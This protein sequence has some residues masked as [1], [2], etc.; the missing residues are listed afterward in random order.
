MKS[1]YAQT[2]DESVLDPRVIR[3][4]RLLLDAFKELLQ[5]RSAIRDVS[6]Q[7]IS[8][9]AGVNRVTFYAHFTDKYELLDFWKRELFR[10]EL[11][12]RQFSTDNPSLEQLID[13]VLEFM[14]NY[15]RN[16]RT[17]INR[18]FEPLFEAAIQNEIQ[19][20]LLSMTDINEDEAIFLSW[21]IFG[22]SNEWSSKHNPDK[23][24]KIASRLVKM[25][26]AVTLS[27]KI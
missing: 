9:R 14:V 10:K 21:A 8:E 4:R 17:R 23:K 6:I 15:R 5:E 27:D 18:Q 7:A 1:T 2:T 25:V 12:K 26:N 13:A 22:S 19:K 16:L 11:A 20:A 24:E 3:T